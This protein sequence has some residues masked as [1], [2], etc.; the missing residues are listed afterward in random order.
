MPPEKAKTGLSPS[1]LTTKDA[2]KA[3]GLAE[4][5]LKKDVAAGAPTNPDGTINIIHY[6]AW[7][8]RM[9]KEEADGLS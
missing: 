5:M 9:A 2:A 1:A 6:A 3:L 8:N 4:D 7:L